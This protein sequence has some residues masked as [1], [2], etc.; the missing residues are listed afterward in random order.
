MQISTNRRK[1]R[2][3][4]LEQEFATYEESFLVLGLHQTTRRGNATDAQRA[5]GHTSLVTRDV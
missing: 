5:A 3:R 2:P 1:R 4:G